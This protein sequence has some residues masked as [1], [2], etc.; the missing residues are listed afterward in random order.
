[1]IA[2]VGR[3]QNLGTLILEHALDLSLL[4]DTGFFSFLQEYF[5]HDQGV[6]NRGAQLGCIGTTL[7]YKLS[8]DVVKFCLG[9]GLVIH[10]RSILRV[11]NPG[12]AQARHTDELS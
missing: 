10:N 11:S 7:R 4:A 2:K 1:M 12:K 8:D 9:N 6:A 3:D 5:L